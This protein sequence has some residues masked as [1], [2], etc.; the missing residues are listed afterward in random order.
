MK[1]LAE[2]K[3]HPAVG[4]VE[5]RPAVALAEESLPLCCSLPEEGKASMALTRVMVLKI[6]SDADKTNKNKTNIR[7]CNDTFDFVQICITY[8]LCS[9]RL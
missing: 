5:D 9:R 8:V 6:G 2:Q 1:R 3:H 4:L 7:T